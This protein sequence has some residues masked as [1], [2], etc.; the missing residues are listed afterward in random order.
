MVGPFSRFGLLSL[1]P[2][3][4]SLCTARIIAEYFKKQN[5]I[6]SFSWSSSSIVLF[7]H[8]NTRMKQIL[9][10]NVCEK[11]YSSKFL[12]LE[13]SLF[14]L[15]LPVLAAVFFACII[16]IGIMCI[17]SW[18][19]HYA[20]WIFHCNRCVLKALVI[21]TSFNTNTNT[22]VFLPNTYQRPSFYLNMLISRIFV[23]FS[24][25]YSYKNISC[26]LIAQHFK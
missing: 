5:Q 16:Y 19:F 21:S 11:E 6:Q 23:F 7:C 2:A 18:N 25:K 17:C 22:H 26:V 24:S 8:H 12:L 20:I 13:Q 9:H 10:R 4:L 14:S 15:L 3:P 1:S